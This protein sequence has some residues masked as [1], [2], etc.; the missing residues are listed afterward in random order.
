MQENREIASQAHRRFAAENLARAETLEA[1]GFADVAAVYREA[2]RL[3]WRQAV[4][5]DS[6]QSGPGR[7]GP[8]PMF[9]EGRLYA[10]NDAALRAVADRDAL[11]EWRRDGLGPAHVEFWKGEDDSGI[12]Y[13]GSDLNAWLEAERPTLDEEILE[14]K[15]GP[16]GG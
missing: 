5:L 15:F 3:H 10:V 16:G 6:L 8:P 14:P 2:A 12:A 13:R 4:R 9:D 7:N 1:D 11:A